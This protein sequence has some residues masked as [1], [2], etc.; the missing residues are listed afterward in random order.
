[1]QKAD[2]IANVLGKRADIL[3]WHG[4]VSEFVGYP[5]QEVVSID[6]IPDNAFT[7]VA[8]GDIHER[9]A[10]EKSDGTVVCYPGSTEL[11]NRREQFDKSFFV[12]EFECENGKNTLINTSTI[13]VATRKV[14]AL[15][16]D[17]NEAVQ[18]VIDQSLEVLDSNP[19]ILVTYHPDFPDTPSR[20]KAAIDTTKCILRVALKRT[21]SKLRPT[22]ETSTLEENRLTML[23][24]LPRFITP[25]TKL[26]G[27]GQQ[28][29]NPDSD[30]KMVLDNYIEEATNRV[31][32]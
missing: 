19:M 9:N 2:F 26:F 17:T 21:S 1:M 25:G 8:L 31:V 28:M 30:A 10:I 14:I 23:D 15:H 32:V 22:K 13:P 16:V 20:L 7:L 24:F 27:V 12:H 6:D 29:I 4:M 3:V 18:D 5:V 11:C